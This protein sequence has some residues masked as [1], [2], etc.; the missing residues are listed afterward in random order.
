MRPSGLDAKFGVPLVLTFLC[1]MINEDRVEKS[2]IG[3]RIQSHHCG[4]RVTPLSLFFLTF[5][6][7]PVDSR[8]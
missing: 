5:W 1:T 7:F 4:G 2:G 3:R 6:E 8:L